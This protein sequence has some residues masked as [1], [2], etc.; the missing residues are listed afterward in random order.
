VYYRLLEIFGKRGGRGGGRGVRLA[1]VLDP[2]DTG[3]HPI[4]FHM[5]VSAVLTTTE[6]V[7]HFV[8]KKIWGH[9]LI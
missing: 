9:I 1:T 7:F 3:L 6:H 2:K 4:L 8:S 5:W